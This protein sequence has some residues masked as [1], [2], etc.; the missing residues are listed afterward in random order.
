MTNQLLS[1]ID[2][3]VYSMD[4]TWSNTIF[5]EYLSELK[6]KAKKKKADLNGVLK[7][8][9]KDEDW[10]FLIKPFGSEGYE[11]IIYGHEYNIKIG[12]WEKP[13]S[14]PGVIIYIRSETLWSNGVIE[15]YQRI[16][17]LIENNGGR[18]IKKNVSRVDLCVDLL[19]NSSEIDLHLRDHITKK[20]KKWAFFLGA[21]NDVQT[22]QIGIKSKIQCTI[23]DKALEIKEKQKKEWFYDLWKIEKIEE[24]KRIIRVE[25]KLRREPIKEMGF[26][27]LE[28]FMANCEQVWAYCTQKWLRFETDKEVHH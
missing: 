25:F 15:S 6:E 3:L 18:I 20:S 1:G 9:A 23:Y 7:G 4:I 24:G 8:R 14:R 13:S 28:K 11:W 27:S 10:P 5:F 17:E 21:S 16:N 12:N 22:I 19:I 2:T 26:G